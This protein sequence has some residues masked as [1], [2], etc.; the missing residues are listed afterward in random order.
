MRCVLCH[1]SNLK[2]TI[3]N[4]FVFLKV[5]LSLFKCTYIVYLIFKFAEMHSCN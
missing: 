2:G 1:S 4:I 5:V 3:C